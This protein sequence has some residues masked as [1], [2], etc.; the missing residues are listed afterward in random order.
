MKRFKRGLAILLSTCMIGGMMP[1]TTSAQEPVSGNTVQTEDTAISAIQAL[2]DALPDADSITEDSAEEVTAQLDTIDE[3]K[4]EL[5]DEELAQLDLTRYDAAVAKMMALMGMEGAGE[6]MSADMDTSP[7]YYTMQPGS[8]L[9][10]TTVP[11]GELTPQVYQLN[12]AGATYTI[13]GKRDTSSSTTLRF[14]ISADCTV[15]LKDT[16]FKAGITYDDGTKNHY[17]GGTHG[18]FEVEKGKTAVFQLEGDSTI[19]PVSYNSIAG[20]CLPGILLKPNAT[21]E[22]CGSGTLD[23]E[24]KIGHYKEI[25]YVFLTIFLYLLKCPQSL[26]L[27][28]LRAFCFCGKPHISRS[29]F[30]YFR[31]QSWLKSW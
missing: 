14:V 25:I 3:A 9:D 12:Q 28:A 2:I 16:V 29:I 10:V 22:F 30:L 7:Q 17:R 15:I 27:S 19:Y 26:I 13:T 24:G 8:T 6:A 18:V 31:Y 5:T 23:I 20:S 4:A 11:M 1:I 21:V